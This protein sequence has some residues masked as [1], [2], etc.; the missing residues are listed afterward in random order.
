MLIDKV[1]T[2]IDIGANRGEYAALALE[3]LTDLKNIVLIEPE[4]ANYEYLLRQFSDKAQV[5]KCA[6]SNRSG[7]GVLGLSSSDKMHSLVQTPTDSSL[8]PELHQLVRICTLR[9]IVSNFE[10]P[11]PLFI[12]TDT[13]GHDIQVIEGLADLFSET[14]GI[15]VEGAFLKGGN[16]TFFQDVHDLLTEKGML[17]WGIYD[18]SP[19]GAMGSC[20][21]VNGMFINPHF[22]RS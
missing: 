22:L 8:N 4:Q 19:W 16:I 7:E 18:Q 17:F 10:L 5:V 14:L 21:V 3:S 11:S 1:K 6:I 2:Y 20:N 12:K 15:V 13:E 9:E